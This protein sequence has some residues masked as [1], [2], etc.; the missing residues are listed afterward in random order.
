RFDQYREQNLNN[1]SKTFEGRIGA[2]EG[3]INAIES[4]ASLAAPAIAAPQ[5]TAVGS[6]ET[7]VRPS[8]VSPTAPT[9]APVSAS[10]SHTPAATPATAPGQTPGTAQPG[11]EPPPPPRPMSPINV[12]R[13]LNMEL[14]QLF[15]KLKTQSE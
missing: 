5:Q 13:A 6:A 11:A 3:R 15:T 10:P 14:K 8:V 1:L 12:R 9:P 2:I 7:P 4:R